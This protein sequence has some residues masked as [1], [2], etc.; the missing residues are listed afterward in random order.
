MKQ[1]LVLLFIFQASFA[2]SAEAPVEAYEGK[3]LPPVENELGTIEKIDIGLKKTSIENLVLRTCLK[4]MQ[5]KGSGSKTLLEGAAKSIEDILLAHLD[6]TRSSKDFEK[7]VTKFWNKNHN[8]F[9]CGANTHYGK[10]HLFKAVLDMQM[11]STVLLGFFLK[12][13]QKYKMNVNSYEMIRGKPETVLDY[14]YNIKAGKNSG[15]NYN[16]PEINELVEILEDEYNALRG[17]DLKP[18]NYATHN[19]DSK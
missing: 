10:K 6:L 14:L 8:N 19:N 18:L 12:E 15:L 2:F 4:L 5:A 11:A 7:K 16:I 1:L 13:D 9:I 17:K 3:G